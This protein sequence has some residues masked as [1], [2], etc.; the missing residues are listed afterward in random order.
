MP[1]QHYDWKVIN[2]KHKH[3]HEYM[4]KNTTV[5]NYLIEL[6]SSTSTKLSKNSKQ[7]KTSINNVNKSSMVTKKP[8]NFLQYTPKSTFP[9]IGV[10]PAK[11]NRKHF[12]K[13]NSSSNEISSSIPN[14]DVSK[15]KNEHSNHTSKCRRRKQNKCSKKLHGKDLFTMKNSSNKSIIKGHNNEIITNHN[16]FNLKRPHTENSSNRF[17][18]TKQ[19]KTSENNV[20]TTEKNSLNYTIKTKGKNVFLNTSKPNEHVHHTR[21]HGPQNAIGNQTLTTAITVTTSRVNTSTE[22]TFPVN[23]T[24]M[25]IENVKIRH[26]HKQNR[27]FKKKKRKKNGNKKIKQATNNTNNVNNELTNRTSSEFNGS[28]SSTRNV[29]SNHSQLELNTPGTNATNATSST[30]GLSNTVHNS[31]KTDSHSSNDLTEEFSHNVNVINVNKIGA[32]SKINHESM[33]VYRNLT[34]EESMSVLER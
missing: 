15:V 20:N 24:T 31:S 9:S 13:T 14:I 6:P 7:Q 19:A 23:S 2:S 17:Q 12:A 28:P 1:E 33:H 30:I 10:T 11:A 32:D 27:H 29:H 26:H 21:T 18:T 5:P 16:E 8:N 34:A 4:R 3:E 22:N 25:S